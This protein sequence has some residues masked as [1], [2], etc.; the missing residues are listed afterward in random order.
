MNTAHKLVLEAIETDTLHNL[1]FDSQGL[2]SHRFMNAF[3][4]AFLKLPPVK[5]ILISEKFQSKYLL[6]ILER[7][8]SENI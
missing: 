2:A 4:G 3:T 5:Q 1:I 7:F 6:N 8:K